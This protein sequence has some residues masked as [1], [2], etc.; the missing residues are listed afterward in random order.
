MINSGLA[1]E[2]QRKGRKA[3]TKE[4]AKGGEEEKKK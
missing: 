2:R 3:V 4:R 1:K